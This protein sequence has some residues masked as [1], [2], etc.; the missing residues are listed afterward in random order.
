RIAVVL[1]A[2]PVL[3]WLALSYSGTRAIRDA[4][5]V[6]AARHPTLA[7]IDAAIGE[8]R[9]SRPL[10]PSRSE[11]LSYAAV[12]E[13]RAG[14]LD[15]ARA[16]LE[17]IVRREPDTPEAW[18]LLAQLTQRSDPARAAEARAQVQRLDPLRQKQR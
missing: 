12:L 8:L 1:L 4:Q 5:V 16:L 11:A 17:E 10:D 15:K 14:R 3:A 2:L 6:A 7:Q 13:I 18:L 9:A